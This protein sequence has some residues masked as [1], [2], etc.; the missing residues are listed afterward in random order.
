MKSPKEIYK[1]V[2][3]RLRKAPT[4]VEGQ[5][6]LPSDK[7]IEK[8]HLEIQGETAY[9]T[10]KSS[11]IVFEKNKGGEWYID[12]GAIPGKLGYEDWLEHRGEIL[13]EFRKW[14]K[15][16][17]QGEMKPEVLAYRIVGT[18]L[19]YAHEDLS[20]DTWT[21]EVFSLAGHL[22]SRDEEVTQENQ[23]FQKL[24]ALIEKGYNDT[25]GMR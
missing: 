13:A 24:K 20:K 9:L 1:E 11:E 17:E 16:V 22:E 23:E 15:E 21:L 6:K 10:L 8:A 18:L 5:G 19:N 4:Y 7:D 12:P 25:F 14:L 3:E 2:V